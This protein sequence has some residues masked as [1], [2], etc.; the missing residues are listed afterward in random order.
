KIYVSNKDIGLFLYEYDSSRPAEKF[1]GKGAMHMQNSNKET[2]IVFLDEAWSHSEGIKIGNKTDYSKII[3]FLKKSVGE[4]DVYVQDDY[5]S[6]YI[7]KMDATGFS[8]EYG[9][10][11]N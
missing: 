1:I 7:F 2:L 6:T 11:Q 8:K 4:I 9:L 5:S 10:L 3:S